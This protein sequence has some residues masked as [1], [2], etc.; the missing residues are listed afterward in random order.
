MVSVSA[1]ALRNKVGNISCPPKMVLGLS[2]QPRRMFMSRTPN[3][4]FVSCR[5]VACKASASSIVTN[6]VSIIYQRAPRNLSDTFQYKRSHGLRSP[7]S[8]EHT[9]ELQSQ[10]HL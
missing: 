9:S 8:E 2:R 3:V 10:F 6:R 4:P 1:A 5:T 7:R